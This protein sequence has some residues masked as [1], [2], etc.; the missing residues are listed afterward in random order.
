MKFWGLVVFLTGMI[1]IKLAKKAL[2]K[3][4]PGKVA[5][6]KAYISANHLNLDKE[7]A[8]AQLVAFYEQLL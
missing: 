5:A 2:L 4:L 6:L 8:A 3:A 1:S 7:D